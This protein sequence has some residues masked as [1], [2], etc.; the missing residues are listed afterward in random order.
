[1]WYFLSDTIQICTLTFYN[2]K[3]DEICLKQSILVKP[4]TCWIYFI[5]TDITNIDTRWIWWQIHNEDSKQPATNP[6]PHTKLPFT[7]T[8]H[9]TKLFTK[10]AND[11]KIGSNL[12]VFNFN[13]L[14]FS[15]LYFQWKHITPV[16][17]LQYFIVIWAT[18][19]T[20]LYP[21]AGSQSN[22]AL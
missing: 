10:A 22:W 5:L 14:M 6:Q 4:V 8:K 16:L 11:D 17:K 19:L 12:L 13:W 7:N 1:M 3:S 15:F 2:L 9:L 20:L 21:L 18:S